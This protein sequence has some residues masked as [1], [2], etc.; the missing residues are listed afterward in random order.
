MAHLYALSRAKGEADAAPSHGPRERFAAKLYT[1]GTY[2]EQL[3]LALTEH[4][5][6]KQFE[7]PNVIAAVAL[8]RDDD[9][10]KVLLDN[11]PPRSLHHGAGAKTTAR[12]D[13]AENPPAARVAI[14]L[15]IRVN[16]GRGSQAGGVNL[17]SGVTV[18]KGVTMQ[19]PRVRARTPTLARSA[20]RTFT[21]ERHQGQKPGASCFLDRGDSSE[22]KVRLV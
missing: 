4:A 20:T 14:G 12:S 16:L 10:K 17:Y 5:H 9:A 15:G 8:L 19:H 18:C 7:H 1:F 6:L 3:D 2:Q 21:A 13:L 11:P 22:C